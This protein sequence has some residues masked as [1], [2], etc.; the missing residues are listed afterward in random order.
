VREHVVEASDG[1]RLA[2]VERGDPG[3]LPVVFHHGTPGSRL[4][5]HPDESVY[6]G[7]RA[8][9]YDRPGYGGSDAL[10]RRTVATAAADTSAIADALGIDRFAVEGGSG[11]GPHALACGALLGERVTKVAVVVGAAPS[12]DPDLDWISGMNDLN[13]AEVAAAQEG[14][15]ALEAFLLPFATQAR[16]NPNAVIEEIAASVPEADQ[17]VMARPAV[18]AI[19]AEGLAESVRQGVCGWA[20]DDLAFVKPWGFELTEVKQEVRL[21]QGELDVLV[22]RAHA[23]YLES[24][25]PHARFDLVP[26]AGH[27]LIDEIPD[28]VRWLLA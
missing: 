6:E 9:F 25:L 18:R 12:D 1:R 10:P 20:D 11:G 19:F 23:E 21:W 15:D 28:V 5:R 8:I 13:R 22:P 27:M 2:V 3:G 24:K 7:V 4:G 14:P 16:T 17:A 26:N